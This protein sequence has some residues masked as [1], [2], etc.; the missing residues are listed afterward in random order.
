MANAP[1]PKR[2][3]AEQ[4]VE[5]ARNARYRLE[6]DGAQY[7][8][9]LGEMSASDVRLLREQAGMSV[10]DLVRQMHAPWD[11]DSGAALLWMARRQAGEKALTFDEVADNLRLDQLLF[12]WHEDDPEPV[13]EGPQDPP[14]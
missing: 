3:A 6:F 11:M 4:R 5:A 9:R 10:P 14:A 2:L 7:T 1:D 12:V 13:E 8:F